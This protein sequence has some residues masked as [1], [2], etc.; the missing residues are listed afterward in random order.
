MAV[1]SARLR[2]DHT[3]VAVFD[4]AAAKSEFEALGFTVISGGQHSGGLTENALVTFADGNYLELIAP[5][6]LELLDRPPQPGPGNYLFLFSS[7][8]GFAGYAFDASNLRAEVARVR[9]NGIDLG[10]P[11]PGG[12]RRPDGVKLAWRTAMLPDTRSPF[13]L[14]DDTPRDRRVREDFEI[15]THPNGAVG[16]I[17]IVIPVEN[18]E[19]AVAWHEV[20]LGV[21]SRPGSSGV[22]AATAEFQIGG[23]GLTLAEPEGKPSP[24]ADHLA[25]RGQVPYQVRIR[26]TNLL[27]VAGLEARGARIELVQG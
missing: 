27:H 16:V 7:G 17:G 2:F 1:A 11:Q 10:D 25:R 4:L 20:L 19:R 13:F 5:T 12:R 3:L 26:T 18:L 24:L 22:G 21:P 14:T 15:T 23:F 9:S 6:S 8:E